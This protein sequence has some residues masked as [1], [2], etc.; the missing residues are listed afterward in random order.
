MTQAAIL[1]GGRGTRLG[2]LTASTPKPLLEVG[3]VPFLDHVIAH[4]RDHG[5]DRFLLLAGFEAMKV[6]EYAREADRRLGVPIYVA[7][8]PVPDAGTGG[9]LWY[10]RHRLDETFILANGDTFFDVDPR[11]LFNMVKNGW[12]SCPKGPVAGLV[13]RLRD[14]TPAGLYV[15]RR[16]VIDDVDAETLSLEE[17]ITGHPSGFADVR[18]DGYFVDIGTPAELE[19][20]RRELRL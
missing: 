4:L 1:V 7:I 5:C 18:L 14:G 12:L 13:A 2:A 11:P 19:R 15:L 20:A 10:A 16:S 17:F 6:V 8:E 3:G 9:A